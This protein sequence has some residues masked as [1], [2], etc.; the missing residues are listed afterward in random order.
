MLRRDSSPTPAVMA[1]IFAALL[2]TPAPARVKRWPKVLLSV[3]AGVVREEICLAFCALS[4]AFPVVLSERED[5][6]LSLSLLLLIRASVV[7]ETTEGA[8]EKISLASSDASVSFPT[9]EAS[10]DH[11]W[12]LEIF[13][14]P[15]VCTISCI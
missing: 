3:A 14:I 8:I 1:D 15:D 10:S 9:Y 4:M 13:Y 5:L 7:L 2:A 12:V 11:M 6:N